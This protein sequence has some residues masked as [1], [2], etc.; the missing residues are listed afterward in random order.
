MDPYHFLKE[1]NQNIMP[2]SSFS[3]KITVHC[4]ELGYHSIYNSD[5]YGFNNP[6]TEWDKN[7]IDFFLVG[8]R[9]AHGDC[10]NEKNTIGGNLRRLSK[11]NSVINLGQGGN[12]PMMELASLREY[13]PLVKAKNV[14]WLYC[15]TNDL[16]GDGR[17]EGLNLELK[18][19]ILKNYLI[20]E[21]F[22][23]NLYLKQELIDLKAK[24]KLQ[25]YENYISKS[26]KESKFFKFIKLF[27]TRY[28]I[29]NQI[30]NSFINKEKIIEQKISKEFKDII[31]K[32]KKFSHYNQS[33]FYFVYLTDINRY[34]SKNF[35]IKKNDYQK[36][37]NFLT[38]SNVNF[39][40]VHKELFEKH[41]N[42]LSLFSNS[43]KKGIYHYN[44]NGY[45]EVANLIFKMV[46]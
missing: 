24:K 9:F 17:T 23:Q 43:K 26:K 18:N 15:E 36:V 30:I 32:A 11:N 40:D 45:K 12:G 14:I 21:N 8:D 34:R 5:R 19:L 38:N 13:L 7:I 33:K 28:L 10:V 2:L 29:K 20:D 27:Q 39:I 35:D 4:N 37:I 6:D 41:H 42:P 3:N 1:K 31:I 46:N 44:E 22:S 25:E 16:V